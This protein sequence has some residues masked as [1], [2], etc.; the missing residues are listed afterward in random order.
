LR[1]QACAPSSARAVG[2]QVRH[3]TAGFAQ[4][5]KSGPMLA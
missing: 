2:R 5:G 4:Q 3:R 1:R